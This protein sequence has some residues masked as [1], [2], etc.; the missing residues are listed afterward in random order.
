MQ[1]VTQRLF[2]AVEVA[3][4]QILDC[5]AANRLA[6]KDSRIV[7]SPA[8]LTAFDAAPARKTVEHRHDGRVGKL[9][10]KRR[11]YIADVCFAQYPQRLETFELEAR[12]KISGAHLW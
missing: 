7:K 8:D 11:L 4:D 6:G 2:G 12:R 10:G 5:D 1:V 9:P 3:I